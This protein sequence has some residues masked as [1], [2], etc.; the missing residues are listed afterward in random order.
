MGTGVRRV[1]SS[2]RPRL[3]LW[4]TRQGEKH[5]PIFWDIGTLGCPVET[6]YCKNTVQRHLRVVEKLLLLRKENTKHQQRQRNNDDEDKE[7]TT[8]AQSCL[9]WCN[10][11]SKPP[12]TPEISEY[13]TT[14]YTTMSRVRDR[15]RTSYVQVPSD[16]VPPL[17]R[18]S[19]LC[20]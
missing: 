19:P 13:P 7:S 11:T 6:E 5:L 15:F 8:A 1:N 9:R 16:K 17:T 18:A 14:K 20:S 3:E 2:C 12:L 4:H 10:D